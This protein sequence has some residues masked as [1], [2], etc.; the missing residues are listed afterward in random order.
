MATIVQYSQGKAAANSYPSKIVSPLFS[1]RC[2]ST[3]MRR[4]GDIQVEGEG[5]YYYKRCTSCG[6]TVREFMSAF[7]IERVWSAE[8]SSWDRTRSWIDRIQRQAGSEM[9]A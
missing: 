5:R 7:D 4:I 6:F 1:N 3:H 2:C 8:L 9:A